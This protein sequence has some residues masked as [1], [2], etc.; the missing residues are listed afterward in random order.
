MVRRDLKNPAER[1]V[2]ARRGGRQAFC[3]ACTSSFVRLVTSLSFVSFVSFVLLVSFVL[4]VP[5][6]APV[7]AQPGRATR[8]QVVPPQEE[9][10]RIFMDMIELIKPSS[11]LVNQSRSVSARKY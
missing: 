1:V 10:K 7:H 4:I 8:P 11:T 5:L 9:A 3:R 6:V 2:G